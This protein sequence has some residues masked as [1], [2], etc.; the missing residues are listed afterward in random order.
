M[1]RC[2][3]PLTFFFLLSTLSFGIV[4]DTIVIG[5]G[6]S[7]SILAGDL[8]SKTEERILCLERGDDVTGVTRDLVGLWDGVY[9]GPPKDLLYVTDKNYFVDHYYSQEVKLGHSLYHPATIAL[10]GASAV[11]G[12]TFG[13]FSKEDLEEWNSPY[14]TFN[15]T[16]NDWKELET[17]NSNPEACN[18]RYHG[19]NGPIDTNTFVAS[20][21]LKRIMNAT[22]EKFNLDFNLDI[23]GYEHGGVGL[24]PR[25]IKLVNETPIR[26]DAW[27]QLLKPV[28]EENSK[29]KVQP[30]AM[31]E[32]IILN[33]NGMNMVQYHHD[34]NTYYA[35]ALKEVVLSAGVFNNPKLLM[36]SGIG[37][38]DELDKFGIDC[39]VHNPEIGQNMHNVPNKFLV[40]LDPTAP[41]SDQP[42][43]VSVAYPSSKTWSGT[44]SDLEIAM[45][46]A[47]PLEN[48]YLVQISKM[49]NSAIGNLSLF[50]SN[51]YRDPLIIFDPLSDPEV[52]PAM[53]ELFKEVRQM[54]T[55]EGFFEISP[56]FSAVPPDA[57]DAQLDAYLTSTLSVDY[58]A[59]G[60]CSM[61]KV[62][63]DRLRLIDYEG[64]TVPGLRVADNSII[65]KLQ[66]SRC[67]NPGAMFIGKVCSRFIQEDWNL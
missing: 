12:G 27:T 55:G 14:W 42:G 24:I 47:S 61:H 31:V 13:R 22:Q 44:G 21:T 3:L 56:G 53:R 25:N 34:G 5:C 6:T 67:T 63:D 40:Y 11:N 10:G 7:G 64:N 59:Q 29:V 32:R 65:P 62:V 1:M 57:S 48:A 17:C 58:H 8:G 20:P 33:K 52:I 19:E 49:K 26:Q 50:S 28:S 54:M 9:S 30:N 16:E 46:S 60:T 39:V 51:P 36:Q 18:S 23:N 2:C 66:S 38:C 15:Q 41:D 35:L 4:Y 43:T 45:T 37:D